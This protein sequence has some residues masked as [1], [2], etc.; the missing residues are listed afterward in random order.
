MQCHRNFLGYIS[1]AEPLL[2][3]DNVPALSL[4]HPM[5]ER[6]PYNAENCALQASDLGTKVR[7][8]S[9][10]CLRVIL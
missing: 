5:P 10:H 7:Y 9:P 3:C 6:A 4:S 1:Q 2:G 8:N